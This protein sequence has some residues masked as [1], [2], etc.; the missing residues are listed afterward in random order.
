MASASLSLWQTNRAVA[1][2]EIQAAHA[3]VG[4]VGPGRRY[5]TQQIN[6]A[7]V[8]LLSGQFQGFCR[9]LHTECVD[10]LVGATSPADI[11]GLLRGG[12]L[13]E[14]KIDRGNPFPGNIGDD[15]NRLGVKFWSDVNAF[16]KGNSQ[17]QKHLETLNIW[18]NSIAHQNFDPL[19]LG[20][21]VTVQL[22][23]VRKWNA[24]CDGLAQSFDAVMGRHLS[25]ILG[26]APW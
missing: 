24:A 20:S 22:V 9:D 23:E 14:R 19:K 21:K 25:T 11:Q 16:D 8:M 7:Y 1:L 6:Q 17:R 12:L 5:A 26:T 3:S 13:H 15:F 10:Y 18:R 4:G 2:Q